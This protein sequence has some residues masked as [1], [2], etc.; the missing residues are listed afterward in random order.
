MPGTRTP[1]DL[2]SWNWK[3][4]RR[5][6]TS[7][8]KLTVVTPSRWLKSLAEESFF[9]G[10]DIRVINN[11]IDL[12]VFKPMTDGPLYKHF[13]ESGKNIVLGVAGT[14]S[15]RKG[16]ETLIRLGKELPG[17]YHVVVV[18][19]D[20]Y[21][22]ENSTSIARTHNASELAELYSVAS[23]FVNPTLEDNFPTVNLEAL[24]CGTPVVTYRTGGS[25]ESISENTG[26]VVEKGDYEALK[27]AVM[28]ICEK[29]KETF[30]DAC[31]EASQSYDMNARFNDYVDLY[32]ELLKG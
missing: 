14:W 29:G 16:L 24:A 26:S 12:S 7:L 10:K 28:D 5:L 25:P 20:E 2:S 4:K 11:G 6:F 3:R 8:D 21:L 23:V 22:G 1:W 27:Q 19:T 30:Q 17:D 18:G 15:T 31:V 32:E 9:A 13:K